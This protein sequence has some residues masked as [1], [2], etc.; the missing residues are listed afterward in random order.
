MKS[1]KPLTVLELVDAGLMP[2]FSS[3]DEYKQPRSWGELAEGQTV[4]VSLGAVSYYRQDD[5][6]KAEI[7][8][9]LP[10]PAILYALETGWLGV[11]PKLSDMR[12]LK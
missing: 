9:I 5:W 1:E 3:T 2:V 11:A 6:V 7:V 4:L 10:D 8:E 12:R